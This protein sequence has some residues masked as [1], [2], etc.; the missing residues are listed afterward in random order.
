MKAKYEINA[1]ANEK[2]KTFDIIKTWN[3]GTKVIYRTTEL[4]DQEFKDMEYNTSNDWQNFLNTNQNY[5]LIDG[6]K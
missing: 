5:Y 6:V 4:T 2:T 1:V 3:D